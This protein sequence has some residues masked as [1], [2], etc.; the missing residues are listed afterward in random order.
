MNEN[1]RA[2]IG[3]DPVIVVQ[4]IARVYVYYKYNAFNGLTID[5]TFGK[6]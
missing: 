1:Y 3:I 5:P 4:I 2:F 6:D